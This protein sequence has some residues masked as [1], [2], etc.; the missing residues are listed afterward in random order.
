MEKE[1]GEEEKGGRRCDSSTICEGGAVRRIDWKSKEDWWTKARLII[2][3]GT[4]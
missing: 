2:A 4:K 1:E 3:E